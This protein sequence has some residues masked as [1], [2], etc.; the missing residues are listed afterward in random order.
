[1]LRE[2]CTVFPVHQMLWASHRFM[3]RSD[4]FFLVQVI[5]WIKI[6]QTQTPPTL[7]LHHTSLVVHSGA[8]EFLCT[9]QSCVLSPV[10]ANIAHLGNTYTAGQTG[11]AFGNTSGCVK[12]VSQFRPVNIQLGDEQRCEMACILGFKP[13]L[14]IEIREPA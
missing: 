13:K 8:H 5:D 9:R 10:E 6:S 3:P 12:T 14:P 4:T 1:M 11:K 7:L 2:K